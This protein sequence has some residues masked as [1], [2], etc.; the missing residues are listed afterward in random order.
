MDA[1]GNGQEIW[2]T[3]A[4]FVLILSGCVIIPTPKHGFGQISEDAAESV[5]IGETT[6]MNVLLRFGE[7]TSRLDEDQL[8]VYKWKVTTAYVGMLGMLPIPDFGPMQDPHAFCIHFDKDGI[9]TH[10]SG[11]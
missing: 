6:R 3:V 9:V 11:C 4:A 10:R 5:R 2:I 7:P 8:F 1:Q